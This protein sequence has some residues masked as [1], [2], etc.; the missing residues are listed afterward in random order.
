VLSDPRPSSGQPAR[1]QDNA[2][3][4]TRAVPVPTTRRL[5]GRDP[6]RPLLG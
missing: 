6:R 3:T 4:M 2:A 5:L 1:L